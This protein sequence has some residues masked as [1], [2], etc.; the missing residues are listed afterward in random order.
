[1]MSWKYRLNAH[2]P[3]IAP[4]AIILRNGYSRT[5]SQEVFYRNEVHVAEFVK[6]VVLHI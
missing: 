2:D 3:S 4:S 1:M 6:L 5:Q